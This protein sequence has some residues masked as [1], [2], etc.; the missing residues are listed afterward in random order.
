MCNKPLKNKRKS[1]GRGKENKDTR[2]LLYRKG[3][4]PKSIK[5]KKPKFGSSMK[6]TQNTGSGNGQESVKQLA[7]AAEIK[8]SKV[9]NPQDF[10]FLT[11]L[12]NQNKDLDVVDRKA[13][14]SEVTPNVSVNN[15][16]NPYPIRNVRAVVVSK[17]KKKSKVKENQT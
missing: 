3:N 10:D 13:S 2:T 16:Q 9:D 17:S 1:T 8:A 15:S 12:E 4:L 6:Y 5:G 11:R 14:S 7:L